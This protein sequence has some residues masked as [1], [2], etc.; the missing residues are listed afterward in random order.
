MHEN[1]TQKVA[2]I[3]EGE[4]FPETLKFLL[5]KAIFL[6]NEVIKRKEK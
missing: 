2:E 4:H 6:E 5:G 3:T 1:F